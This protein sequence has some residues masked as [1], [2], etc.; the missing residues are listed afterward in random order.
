[1]KIHDSQKSD[2]YIRQALS[3]NNYFEK[4]EKAVDETVALQ[5]YQNFISDDSILI[6]H[7]ASFDIQT[8]NSRCKKYGIG[9]HK[10]KVYDT[11]KISQYLFVPILQE[12]KSRG[13]K[14]AE[15][16]IKKLTKEA[17]HGHYSK[18]KISSRLGDLSKALVGKIENWHTAFDDVR[19]LLA[20]FQHLK[21]FLEKYL[22]TDIY[23]PEFRK[24][25]SQ[26][27][28]KIARLQRFSRPKARKKS[29]QIHTTLRQFNT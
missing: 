3:L 24:H 19:T 16:M 21:L 18:S 6:A 27:R 12:L 28:D 10:N 1:M 2:W 25:F 14:E 13:V 7:N 11:L 29:K 8:I 4:Q 26:Q 17:T 15:E 9:T 20:V 22:D 23:G 5:Y